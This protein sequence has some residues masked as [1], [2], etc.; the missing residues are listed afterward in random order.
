MVTDLLW[1]QYEREKIT[2][3]AK[4]S[5]VDDSEECYLLRQRVLK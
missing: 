4:V 5:D 3:E 2:T 1:W